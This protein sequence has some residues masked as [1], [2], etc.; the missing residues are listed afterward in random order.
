MIFLNYM[1]LLFF[2]MI[3]LQNSKLNRFEHLGGYEGLDGGRSGRGGG[4]GVW[5][6]LISKN[7][8]HYSPSLKFLL[9][10]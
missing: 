3:L 2:E 9:I 5:N 1:Y 7:L 8:A 10:L 4:G 6:S